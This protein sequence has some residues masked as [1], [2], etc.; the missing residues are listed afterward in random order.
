[1][2][3]KQG[4]NFT[5]NNI[6]LNSSFFKKEMIGYDLGSC[7]TGMNIRVRGLFYKL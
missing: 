5:P 3:M 2:V 1:M 4:R 7:P 6:E